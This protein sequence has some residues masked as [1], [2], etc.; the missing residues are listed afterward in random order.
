MSWWSRR[1]NVGNGR[2]SGG[3]LNNFSVVRLREEK[4]SVA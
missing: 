1:W 2:K 4:L 3:G